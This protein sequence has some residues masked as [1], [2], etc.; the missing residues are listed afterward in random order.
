MR[1]IRFLKPNPKRLGLR[2][3]SQTKHRLTVHLKG[4]E[5]YEQ[6]S[7]WVEG[8]E[9]KVNTRV[10]Q[11]KFTYS[12]PD[13]S[14]EE[15]VNQLGLI[16]GDLKAGEFIHQAIWGSERFDKLVSQMKADRQIS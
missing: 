16:N 11:P 8:V 12:F 1:A 13:L 5:P 15:A 10:K 14:R 3:K 2:P 7:K 9:A 4:V 6:V